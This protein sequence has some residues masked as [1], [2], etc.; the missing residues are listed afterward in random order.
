MI[1]SMTSFDILEET[2]QLSQAI[3]SSE[4]FY[5]FSECKYKMQQDK[6]AQQLIKR[7]VQIK[8]DYEEVQRFGKYHPNFHETSKIVREVKREI[9]LNP[10]ISEY[11]KAEAELEKLLIEISSI[12]ASNVSPHIKVPT[13]NP[14]FDQIACGGGCGSGGSCGCK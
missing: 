3:L 8:E 1:T 10:V 9:D 12:I 13:G 7:F 5:H 14:Y 11:K 2:H 6:Q 4:V